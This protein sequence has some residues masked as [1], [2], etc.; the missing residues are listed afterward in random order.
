M[1]NVRRLLVA[2]LLVLSPGQGIAQEPA[3]DQ[4]AGAGRGGRIQEPEIRPYDR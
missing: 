1:V 4:P 2:L 3:Q